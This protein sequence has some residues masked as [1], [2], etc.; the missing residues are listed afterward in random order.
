MRWPDLASLPLLG[1][2]LVA[3][4]RKRKTRR[5]RAIDR[6]LSGEEEK[7]AAVVGVNDIKVAVQWPD[8][9]LFY[10]W[11]ELKNFSLTGAPY[12]KLFQDALTKAKEM[13]LQ[14]RIK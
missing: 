5:K 2:H 14:V 13:G 10:T 3:A 6:K 11:K 1:E 4:P 8:M 9:L 7:G 12:E